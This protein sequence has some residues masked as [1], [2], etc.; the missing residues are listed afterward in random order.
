MSVSVSPTSDALGSHSNKDMALKDTHEPIITHNGEPNVVDGAYTRTNDITTTTT[1]TGEEQQPISVDSIVIV[2][3]ND[4]HKQDNNEQPS[5]NNDIIPPTEIKPD[6]TISSTSSSITA[7][8]EPAPVV[9]VVEAV[10]VNNANED[11]SIQPT[12]II[13]NKDTSTP[14]VILTPV[15]PTTIPTSSSSSSSS[16]PQ[17]TTTTDTTTPATPTSRSASRNDIAESSGIKPRGAI[18]RSQSSNAANNNIDIESTTIA[19]TNLNASSTSIGEI[20]TSSKNIRSSAYGIETEEETDEHGNKQIRKVKRK[21]RTHSRIVLHHKKNLIGETIFKGHQS[22]VLMLNI[23]TGIRNAVGR[24]HSRSTVTVPK[25]PPAVI[26]TSSSPGGDVPATPKSPIEFLTPSV[27]NY[28]EFYACP[29]V[30][31]FPPGGTANTIPH[32]TGPFKF[33]D[34]CP[35]AFRFLR[36][37]FGIDTADYMVSLCNTLK[38]GENALRELPTPGKSGSLFFFSHDMRFIIKT[39]PK[40]EAKLLIALLPSYVDHIANDENTL[41]PK[42]FGLHRVKPHR[43]RQVRFLIMNNIFQ[44]RKTIHERYDLKGST[45]GRQASDEEKKKST[46]TYKD[47]DFIERGIKITIGPA[48]RTQ[49][50]DQLKRDVKFLAK[51]HIMDYSLLIGV[52]NQEKDDGYVSGP[53]SPQPTSKLL[54]PNSAA[55]HDIFHSIFQENDGGMRGLDDS[56]V[57]N[58]RYYYMGIID[59]LMLYSIRKKVEHT[60]KTLRYGKTQQISSV[61]PNEYATRF[62]EFA[63]KALT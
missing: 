8:S 37:R 19:N 25:L 52:H 5:N 38:N 15:E 43:G 62:Y 39:I 30:L 20:R 63:E 58:G 51:L 34:Y 35:H 33:K 21:E 61:S 27:E 7:E 12:T 18:S 53:P 49:L 41:L 16:V 56:G 3:S 45:L 32:Q 42:F 40:S 23:Q 14:T 4:I 50:L 31:N 44:T 11:V 9:L 46:V 28:E 47:L 54:H 48:L 55:H 22:W 29:K 10:I 2:D 24:G 1:N 17:T 26:G 60:Y 57:A 36:H 6:P 13:D 59:I